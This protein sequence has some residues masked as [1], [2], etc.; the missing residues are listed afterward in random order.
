M[1]DCYAEIYSSIPWVLDIFSLVAIIFE[2]M[3][4]WNPF[5]GRM[6]SFSSNE[7][8]QFEYINN[9]LENTFEKIQ[10]TCLLK[11]MGIRQHVCEILE[12]GQDAFKEREI[13]YGLKF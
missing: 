2:C 4:E 13:K 8:Y 6:T 7:E 10:D 11:S 12:G 9:A 3:Y 5:F 1:P